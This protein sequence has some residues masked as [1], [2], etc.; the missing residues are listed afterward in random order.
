MENQKE[1]SGI[2]AFTNTEDDYLSEAIEALVK[3]KNGT[4]WRIV[5]MNQLSNFIHRMQGSKS[6]WDNIYNSWS[7]N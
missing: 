4:T 7:N 2:I 5:S 3:A 1:L 6:F